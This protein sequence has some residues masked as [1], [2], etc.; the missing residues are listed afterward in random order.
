MKIFKN[1]FFIF[2]LC[3]SIFL[4]VFTATLAITGS[5]N[6]IR[7][8]ISIAMTPINYCTEKIVDAYSGFIKYFK[9][10]NN[11]Y[12]E[13]IELK[14]EIES[15]RS[16]IYEGQF[17]KEEN[18]RLKKYLDIA[19]KYDSFSLIEG[20]IVSTQSESYMTIFTLNRGS[21]DGV[22][23]GMPVICTEGVVGSVC[24]VYYSQCKV[25]TITEASSGVGVYN[26]RTGELGIL[27][28]DISYK[29]TGKCKMLLYN[30]ESDIKPGD[31]IYTSGTGTIYP[32]NLLI[33]SVESIEVNDYSRQITATVLCSTNFNE[34][35]NV[36]IISDFEI[37][38]EDEST[39]EVR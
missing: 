28:G 15:L 24:E 31:L 26:S 4:S 8:T 9:G 14:R 30:T 3:I 36:L 12:E 5:G 39:G 29:G 6:I 20:M 34:L 35:K 17:I 2:C 23:L 32:R 13:N 19:E 11:L 1:K 10:F 7:N 25:R 38:D 21:G 33:G 27:K 22:K 37:I 16:D 18:D